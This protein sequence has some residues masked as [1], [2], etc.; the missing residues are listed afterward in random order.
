MPG[1]G[2]GVSVE[3]KIVCLNNSDDHRAV[4]ISC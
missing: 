4:L 1:I 3:D 2:L